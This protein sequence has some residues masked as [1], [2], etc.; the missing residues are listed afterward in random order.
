M[1][2]MLVLLLVSMSKLIQSLH[3]LMQS[4]M[5]LSMALLPVMS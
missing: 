5:W 4:Q 3:S 2:V 1:E